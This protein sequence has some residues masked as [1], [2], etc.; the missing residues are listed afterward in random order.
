MQPVG[1][2]L[3]VEDDPDILVSL[4]LFLKN[5]FASVTTTNNPN[6][7]PSILSSKDISV[8][9]LD[10][11]FKPGA[12][13]GEEGIAWLKKILE[14]DADAVVIM[15]TAYG[16]INLAVNAIKLGATDFITKPW[17]ND[18]LI[19]TLKTVIKLRFSRKELNYLKQKQ[20]QILQD[21]DR[22]Y[23]ILWG[24]S[25]VMNELRIAVSKVAQTDT[26]VLIVGENGTGKDLVA[27]E[28][29]RLSHRS[30]EVFIKVD[31]GSLNENVFES[32]MF[33]HTKGAFT[34]AKDEKAGRFEIAD[35]GTL[36]IDEIGNLSL[37][38]QSKLLTAIQNREINRV[39]SNKTVHFDIRLISATNK[40]IQRLVKENL[41]RQDLLY[42]IETIRIVVPPLRDRGDD[43]LQLSDYFLE[44]Y[45]IK[46][47]KPQL[48][49]N[50]DAQNKLL[51][52]NWPGNVRELQ[53][54]IE[55]SVIMTDQNILKPSD[56]NFLTQ[57]ES[58]VNSNITLNLSDLERQAIEL[59]LNK[60]R[61]NLSETA[62]ELGISRPTLYKKMEK[63][64]IKP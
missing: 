40:D 42:R 22:D 31:I 17:D 4:N 26:S 53:H 37:Y 62:K 1:N 52:Y 9:I 33:G 14:I 35:K 13:S 49:L 58:P 48:K 16:D 41:F 55:K 5:E 47:N 27:R 6:E 21:I 43:I 44:K 11:N 25:L 45:G 19:A 2:I 50:G 12:R 63:Y 46:Y 59:A 61:F 3:I 32:E 39:G 54:A 28:I 20:K 15:L 10:M 23:D 57:K 29:H 64:K 36:F 8:I 51:S 38:L 18:K 56:F 34:D 30:N 7:I 60:N 24:R